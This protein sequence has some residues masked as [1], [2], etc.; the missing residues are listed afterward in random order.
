MVDILEIISALI[1]NWIYHPNRSPIIRIIFRSIVFGGA[2]V[3]VLSFL[4]IPFAFETPGLLIFVWLFCFATILAG[5]YYHGI[6][7]LAFVAMAVGIFLFG[8]LILPDILS[9][10]TVLQSNDSRSKIA[11]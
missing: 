8:L 5:E 1:A 10:D 6:P 3:A 9:D 2:F 7:Q 4:E 11:E